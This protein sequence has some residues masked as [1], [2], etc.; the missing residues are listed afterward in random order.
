MAT[1]KILLSLSALALTFHIVWE[2]L[3]QTFWFWPWYNETIWG[4]PLR[5][6]LFWLPYT[7]LFLGA[8]I[9]A[10]A[11]FLIKAPNQQS[12]PEWHKFSTYTL[13]ALA[14]FVTG[15]AIIHS[16]KVY[17][18]DYLYVPTWLRIFIDIIGCAW[19]WIMAIRPNVPELPRSLRSII[20]TGI[21]LIALLWLLQ[22][23]S[24]ISYLTT[25]HILMFR[26]HAFGS[27]LRY[28]VPTV[29]LCSYSI[30]VLNKWPS[31][32]L[33]RLHQMRNS[34]CT[35][36]SFFDRSYPAMRIASLIGVVL[37]LISIYLVKIW[38]GSFDVAYT[39]FSFFALVSTM[40][41]SWLLLTLVAFFQLPNPRCYKIFNW[42][43]LALFIIP[44]PI[45][46]T[47][48]IIAESNTVTETIGVLSMLLGIIA[49]SLH[50]LVTSIRVILYHI[51]NLN[52]QQ[53]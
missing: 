50:I 15:Y 38:I 2:I 26:S 9:L 30:F 10:A 51:P 32:Q 39:R 53:L 44:F 48:G 49:L 47:L 6:E 46:L 8:I 17:G 13:S 1:R 43:C 41:L 27:W 4:N 14:F 36:G 31:V 11:A 5:V 22:L 23:S 29:L 16:V 52:T 21:G 34:H 42:L 20:E 37:V 24:G 25:G 3:R 45:G 33:N 28:L 12:V 35:P 40:L 18:V 7:W 19:L